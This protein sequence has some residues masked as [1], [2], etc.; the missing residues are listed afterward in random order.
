M[1]KRDTVHKAES[2]RTPEQAFGVMLRRIRRGQDLSQ[3]WLADRSGYHRTYIGLL[4]KGQKSPSL[5]TIWNIATSLQLKPSELLKQVEDLV[6][7]PRTPRQVE[8]S[9]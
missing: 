2:T 5:R 9:H 3:Q 8:K 4:E 6:G 1:R 7:N